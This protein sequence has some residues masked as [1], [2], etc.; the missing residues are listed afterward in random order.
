[1]G[2]KLNDKNPN[3]TDL[4]DSNRP[5]KIAEKYNELYDNE[6][7][8]ALEHLAEVYTEENAITELLTC[9]QVN[10]KVTGYHESQ[11]HNPIHVDLSNGS[12]CITKHN[13]C[14]EAI[15]S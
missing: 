8:D 6:W 10:I 14:I 12:I 9:I 15:L 1:M 4:S 7:T 13:T 5:T 11:Y 2:K 3:I